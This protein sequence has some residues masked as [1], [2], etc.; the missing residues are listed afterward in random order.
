VA[1]DAGVPRPTPSP[2]TWADCAFPE[3]FDVVDNARERCQ[4]YADN[5]R[6][7]VDDTNKD[8]CS[9]RC[10]SVVGQRGRAERHLKALIAYGRHGTGAR[11]DFTW[12]A[13]AQAAG[14]PY[15]TARKAIDHTDVEQVREILDKALDEDPGSP[16]RRRPTAAVPPR[17]R[18][19]EDRPSYHRSAP[20]ARVRVEVGGRVLAVGDRDGVWWAHVVL[21]H[22][23]D[24]FGVEAVSGGLPAWLPVDM[25]TLP[26]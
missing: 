1:L 2:P 4:A 19:H 7:Q 11:P 16:A 25:L 5:L 18:T 14:L 20:G 24:D 17:R 9:P 22:G 8:P 15:S 3:A 10:R 23:A 13:L 12:E 6:A 26:A 21:A